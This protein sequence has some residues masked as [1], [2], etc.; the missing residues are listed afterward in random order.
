MIRLLLF[1]LLVSLLLIVPFRWIDPPS[2]AYMLQ[3]QIL[4]DNQ[5]RREWVDIESISPAMRLAVIASEDQTFPSHH[6]LDLQA[7]QTAVNEY[8]RGEGLRGASTLSQQVARN[9]YLWNG[10]NFV[11]KG[12]EA[13][14]A[15]ELDLLWSKRRIL[16]IYLNIAQFGPNIYGA[17]AAARHYF[18]KP[19]SQLSVDEAAALVVMLPAPSRYSVH[20]P[21]PYLTER[22]AWVQR[23][24]Q[25]LGGEGFLAEHGLD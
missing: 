7:I 8:Q 17:E 9:L 13:A 5:V 23:Q 11:R 16:E 10:R 20:D 12:L 18:G 25:A 21:G 3:E 1:L 6:G 22:R 19:A 15:A 24:M 2:S 14:L 4:H